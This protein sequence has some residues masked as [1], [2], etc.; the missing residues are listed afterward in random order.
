MDSLLKIKYSSEVNYLR[1]SH[2]LGSCTL[3]KIRILF[4][5]PLKIQTPSRYCVA[6]KKLLLTYQIYAASQFFARALSR[7]GF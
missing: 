3:K 7:L 1:P 6:H 4:K 5:A 2:P